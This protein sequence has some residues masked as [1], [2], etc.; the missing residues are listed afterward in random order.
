M[1]KNI[2][3]EN[4]KRFNTKNLNENI[5][6]NS[7]FIETIETILDGASSGEDMSDYIL[8][9]LG[10]FYN[11]VT[12]SNNTELKQL[13]TQ[14]RMSAD[15]TTA[16]QAKH[17]DRLL[18]YLNKSS[19]NSINTNSNLSSKNIKNNADFI[20]TVETIMVTSLKGENMTDYILA[21]LGD[22]Y[23]DVTASNNNE[24]K[25]LYKNLRM[26]A[27]ESPKIQSAAA[28]KLYSYLHES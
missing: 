25:Q 6:T 14:L 18:K 28:I 3:V 1:K 12:A 15:G 9:E 5:E 22:F 11:D 23:N 20:E 2:L 16:L 27:D 8:A 26:T 4:M 17:A 21:E 7:D 13:Y 10:D 24:L 19:D